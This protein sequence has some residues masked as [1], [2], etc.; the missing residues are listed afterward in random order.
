MR[1]GSGRH[2]PRPIR[3]EIRAATIIED[4]ISGTLLGS[5][6]GEYSRQEPIEAGEA[7]LQA[8]YSSRYLPIT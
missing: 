1:A 8:N 5:W 6:D 4:Y 7:R 2:T 3:C